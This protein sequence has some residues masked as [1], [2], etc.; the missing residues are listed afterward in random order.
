[1]KIAGKRIPKGDL[2]LFIGFLAVSLCLLLILSA[3]RLN[4]QNRLSKKNLYTE[5]SR[6]FFISYAEKEE[7]WAEALAGVSS[8]FE[9]FAV[10]LPIPES[11]PETRGIYITGEI[12]TPPMLWGKY[13]DKETSWSDT[14]TVVLGKEYEKNIVKRDGGN[15]YEY[16]DGCWFEVIGVMGTEFES[17]INYM[18]LIDFGS[19][20]ARAGINS[21]YVLDAAEPSEISGVGS[22]LSVYF[23]S[24]ANFF[25][26]LYDVADTLTVKDFLKGEQIMRTMSVAIFV[27]FFLS[28]VLASFI[29]F[30]HRQQLRFLWQL[31]GYPTRYILLELAKRF[32]LTAFAGFGIGVVFLMGISLWI[33]EL[34]I[35]MTDVLQAFGMTVGLGTVIL[36]VCC[37]F[38]RASLFRS[39]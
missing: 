24:P 34:Q 8:E 17:R 36:A 14:P 28:T 16:E 3:S 13:F 25:I 20:L 33:E 31:C 35:G 6:N 1:M 11:E 12:D 15:Y 23:A 10:Y 32:Y 37:L 26:M 5:Y 38:D 2:L 7:V 29:W 4:R 19:A 27:S 22:K 39:I 9:D 30:R 18:I 21:D